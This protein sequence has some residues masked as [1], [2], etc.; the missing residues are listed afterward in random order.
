MN[1]GGIMVPLE[2]KETFT[3]HFYTSPYVLDSI[4]LEIGRETHSASLR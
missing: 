3:A 4:L 1:G 2:K